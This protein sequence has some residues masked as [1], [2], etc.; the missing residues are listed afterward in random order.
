MV[1]LR[2][3]ISSSP[4]RTYILMVQLRPSILLSPTRTYNL[5]V[6][7][8]PYIS[9]S[10]TWY[11]LIYSEGQLGKGELSD[12]RLVWDKGPVVRFEVRTA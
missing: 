12:F 6:H 8:R 10:P 2:P 11:G 5:M 9:F 1:Q 4:I 7:I 3:C